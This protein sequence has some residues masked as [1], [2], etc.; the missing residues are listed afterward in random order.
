MSSLRAIVICQKYFWNHEISS[1]IHLF[2]PLLNM[3]RCTLWYW[4]RVAFYCFENPLTSLARILIKTYWQHSEECMCRLRN[5]AMRDYQE[6][7]YRTDT[8]NTYGQTDRRRTKWSLCADMLRRRHNKW[9]SKETAMLIC[10]YKISRC[11]T[12]CQVDMWLWYKS[13]FWKRNIYRIRM[14]IHILTI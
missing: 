11:W 1:E 6:S 9:Y 4:A 12:F 10:P 2:A 5:I 3:R 13:V 8:H 7:D 14:R